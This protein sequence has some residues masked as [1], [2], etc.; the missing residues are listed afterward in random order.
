MNREGSVWRELTQRLGTRKYIWYGGSA[1]MCVCVCVRAVP[2]TS[3]NQSQRLQVNSSSLYT[4]YAL[5]GG[6]MVT[7]NNKGR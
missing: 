4:V 3:S 7:N 6:V 5:S 1:H 2:Q